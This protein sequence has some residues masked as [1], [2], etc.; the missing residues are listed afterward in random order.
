MK[1][2]GSGLAFIGVMRNCGSVDSMMEKL[3]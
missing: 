2:R 1:I 3:G